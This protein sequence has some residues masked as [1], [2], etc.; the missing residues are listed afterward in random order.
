MSPEVK[1][2]ICLSYGG[3]MSPKGRGE[4][5]SV[6]CFCGDRPCDMPQLHGLLC[7]CGLSVTAP[8]VVS[9][10]NRKS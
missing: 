6:T 4:V 3:S 2:V 5:E 8:G 10:S 1:A 9:L 7:G